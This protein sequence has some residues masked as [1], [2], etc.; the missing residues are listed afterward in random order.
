MVYKIPK[1]FFII[2]LLI[3]L[4]DKSTS[5]NPANLYSDWIGFKEEKCIKVFDKNN[6]QTYESAKTICLSQEI[7]Y[8][9]LIMI[10]SKEEQDFIEQLLFRNNNIAN[11][12]WIEA[13][14]EPK[15]NKFHW[16]D[17]SD[18]K[19]TFENWGHLNN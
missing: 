14:R 12:V 9:S 3:W 6:I 19:F 11:D 4:I 8:P 5:A 1:I 10:S 7:G 17:V 15:T 16:D 18:P 13:E 2:I